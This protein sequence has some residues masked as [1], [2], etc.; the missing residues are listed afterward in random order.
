MKV[1]L[2]DDIS[3][4]VDVIIKRL[5][6]LMD[7]DVSSQMKQHGLQYQLNYGA[8]ILWLRQLSKEYAYSSQL[9]NRLWFRE[10]R[11]TMILA[12]LIAE[13]GEGIGE[14]IREWSVV[15]KQNEIAEQLGQI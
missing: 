13:E 12:T 5:N 9:A 11:E 1:F 15:L 8:S 2:Q 7:G 4:R 3:D 6:K 10:I 14:M